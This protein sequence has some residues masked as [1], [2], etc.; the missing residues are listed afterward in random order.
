MEDKKLSRRL[1]EV[2]KLILSMEMPPVNDVNCNEK[3]KLKLQ[4]TFPINLKPANESSCLVLS[5]LIDAFIVEYIYINLM[6]QYVLP[7]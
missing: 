5:I 1:M 4:Q 2:K 7:C 6:S 3:K